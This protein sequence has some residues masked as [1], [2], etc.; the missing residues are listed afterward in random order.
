MIDVREFISKRAEFS[1]V[2]WLD[3]LTN[4]LGLDPARMS[5]RE[6]LLYLSRAIPLVESN[7]NS[8]ELG[9]AKLAK[10]TCSATSPTMPM[11]FRAARLP[12]QVSLST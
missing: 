6:K 4:S 3:I 12:R 8:I 2:E 10:L 9:R 7:D 11:C 1:D 5:R